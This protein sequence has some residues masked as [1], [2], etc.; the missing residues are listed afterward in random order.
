M[1]AYSTLR[2]TRQ[3]AINYIQG[4]LIEPHLPNKTLERI[5]DEF[6]EPQLYNCVISD[7]K[8]DFVDRYLYR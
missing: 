2:F 4:K 8:D 6:L 5:I 1:S 7:F 3:E